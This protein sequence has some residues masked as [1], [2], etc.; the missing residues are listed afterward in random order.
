MKDDKMLV[1]C[2]KCMACRILKTSEWTSR[3]MHELIGKDGSFI[4]LTY[5]EES[6][7]ANGTV[8]KRH[9]QLFIKRLRKYLGK[10][11]IKYYGVG[12]YG[13]KSER[14]HYH[15]IVIGWKPDLARC[16]KPDRK[17]LAS[18]E[19]EQ[20]WT[21]GNNTVGSADREAIQYVVGYIRKKLTGDL[22][23]VQYEQ[24]GRIPPFALQSQGLGKDF[25]LAHKEYVLSERGITRNGVNV[26]V[27]RYYRKKL[28]DKG[29]PEELEYK[30]RCADIR[31]ERM[32][33]YGDVPRQCESEAYYQARISDQ[34]R[35]SKQL[36]AQSKLFNNAKI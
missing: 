19:I 30:Q 12:E 17:Y 1:P 33:K 29:S 11:K 31:Y 20:I 26:C 34:E 35:R 9:L 14:P 13:E 4:T 21:Y 24:T 18:K 16:Y 2:G 25:A 28:I 7:P 22:G 15:V 5:N 27:P 36:E 32:I 8:V 3:I 6:R 10:Q 23:T